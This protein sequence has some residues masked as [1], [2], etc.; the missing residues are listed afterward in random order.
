MCRPVVDNRRFLAARIFVSELAAPRLR[1]ET[2]A[3]AREITMRHVLTHT[4]GLSHG[5]DRSGRGTPSQRRC[6]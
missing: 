1:Y 5:F 3:C 6:M 4:A 2:N